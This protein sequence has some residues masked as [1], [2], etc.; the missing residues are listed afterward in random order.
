MYIFS[1]TFIDLSF[2]AN[3]SHDLLLYALTVDLFL[4]VFACFIR[5]MHKYVSELV[6]LVLRIG[7]WFHMYGNCRNLIESLVYS[8]PFFP[9]VLQFTSHMYASSQFTTCEYNSHFY[10][11]GHLKC[12]A[13]ILFLHQWIVDPHS[14]HRFPAPAS[15]LGQI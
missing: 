10:M 2:C 12:I 15:K 9:F 11:M 3:M 14:K 8:F 4:D 1:A 7:C 6:S 13:V 5:W